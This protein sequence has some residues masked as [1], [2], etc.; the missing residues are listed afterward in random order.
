[1]AKKI[2]TLR[3]W[4]LLIF[5]ILS[6]FAIN[7]N[8]WAKGVEI[9]TVKQGSISAENGISPR[10]IILSINDQP[11]KNLQ[12]YKEIIEKLKVEPFEITVETD[13]GNFTYNITTNLGFETENITVV[14]SDNSP[15]E[16]GME[17]KKINNQEVNSYEDI[18]NITKDLF[19]KEKFKIVTNKREYAFLLT[20]PPQITVKVS[21]KTNL[22]K[23]LDL[24]G[25]TR[26]LI[27][28]ESEKE[29]TNQEI[30]DLIK[31]MSNRLNVYGLKD[32]K[33]RSANDWE[34]NK[35]VLVEIA[36][37]TGEEVKELIAKQG[38]FEA[39]IG[40]DT[41]FEG[42]KKDIT[43]VCRGDG[44]CSGIRDC[45]ITPEGSWY[46]KFEFVIHLSPEAAK[47]HAIIT[48]EIPTKITEDGREILEET[49]DFYL[50]GK[51]VD[52]LQINSDLKG[53]EATAIAISGPGIAPTQ[54][55][56]IEEAI[57]NMDK[58]QTVLITGSLPLDINIVK[59]D[60]ISPLFGKSFIKNSLLVGFFAIVSVSLVVFVRYKNFKIILPMVFTMLSEL[61]IILGFASLIKWNLDLAAIAGIIAAIGTGVDDQI[62]IT[63]EVL[64]GGERFINWKEKIKR[65]FFIIIT[66]YFTTVAAMIPLWN[67]GAGLVRGFAV[68][69]IIGITIG[70][71]LTRP[72][73]ASVIEK[74]LNR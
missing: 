53:N 8:P 50:D 20:G 74:L 60:T 69:T 17:I 22:R 47:N 35:Y 9:N 14:S 54:K 37:I 15:L 42:G 28:P 7:P 36:D 63:D 45:T 18:T 58:L 12:D 1:M 41:V 70:V 5:L 4:I 52:S 61:L 13:R 68:T 21:E 24:A 34:G 33:I 64:R 56:A 66:A 27:K 51:L 57:K 55:G 3:L 49:I 71:F 23:G 2:M 26:V 65:S 10:E 62:V 73:Y 67:A 32:L 31:V 48:A 39:K 19:K 38:K 16:Y 46:C 44:S 6:V 29:I 30:D 43:F 40:N 11:I 25:G 72:A 59:I